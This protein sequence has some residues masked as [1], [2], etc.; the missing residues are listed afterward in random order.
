VCIVTPVCD[1]RHP[2]MAGMQRATQFG[3]AGGEKVKALRESAS[4]WSD[5]RI[6]LSPGAG[7]LVA[8]SEHPFTSN[9]ASA[10]LKASSR[11]GKAVGFAGRKRSTD[12]RNA[13]HAGLGSCE[14]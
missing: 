13:P 12:N 3:G 11:L 1:F 8:P 14:A 4:S 7:V 5:V 6:A 10:S 9:S 2:R